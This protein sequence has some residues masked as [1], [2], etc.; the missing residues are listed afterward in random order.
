MHVLW[1]IC[2]WIGIIKS[3]SLKSILKLRK[4]VHVNEWGRFWELIIK[5]TDSDLGV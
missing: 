5:C 3:M 2:K 1:C 4:I